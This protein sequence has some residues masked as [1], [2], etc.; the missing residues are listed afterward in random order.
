[1]HDQLG[2]QAAPYALGALSPAER[3]EFEAHLATCAQCAA[4][5]RTFSSVAGELAQT[6]P[7]AEP[8]PAVRERLMAAIAGGTQVVGV[9][10]DRPVVLPRRSIAPWL[11]A[12]ASLA[13]AAALGAYALQL[14]RSAS[15]AEFTAE[16]LAAPDLAQVVLAG[17]PAA[18]SASARAFWSRSRG[19][20]FNASNMPALPA[21]STYQLWVI[22][23]QAPPIS[24]GLIKP[25]ASGRVIAVFKT[26]PDL[27]QPTA[28]AVT[29]EPDGGVPAPTGDKYLVGVAN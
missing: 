19:L 8:S 10:R 1:M 29:I 21:G 7:A 4:E 5:V 16:V 27:P 22:P 17:Q 14:R 23:A 13:L 9:T 24:A 11:A 12:A 20:V 15:Q 25:D 26:P 6:A 28:M 18:P 2:E 3:A